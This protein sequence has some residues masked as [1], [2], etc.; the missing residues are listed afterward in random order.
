MGTRRHGQEGTVA[1]PPSLWKFCKVFLCTS[2]Y[3][4][5]LSKQSIYAL[6]SQPFGGFWRLRPQIPT[7]APSRTPQ[8]HLSPGP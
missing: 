3:T 7:K 4:K 8:R 1:P 2:S 6:L 5:M